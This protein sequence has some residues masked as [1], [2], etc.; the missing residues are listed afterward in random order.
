MIGICEETCKEKVLCG[1]ASW[2][3]R[4]A[5][6]T[7]NAQ[8]SPASGSPSAA[9]PSLQANNVNLHYYI[10]LVQSIRAPIVVSPVSQIVY[11]YKIQ[12]FIVANKY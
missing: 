12:L 5:T 2:L 3:P 9:S 4:R 6:A 1:C 10:L 8:R 11:G 7:R